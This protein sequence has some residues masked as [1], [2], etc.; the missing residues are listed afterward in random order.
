MGFVVYKEN[1]QRNLH[2]KQNLHYSLFN[3]LTIKGKKC[4]IIVVVRCIVFLLLHTFDYKRKP[5]VVE[6]IG[7]FGILLNCRGE[8]GY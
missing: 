1:L 2:L 8:W 7:V 5:E 6:M 4:V 3:K